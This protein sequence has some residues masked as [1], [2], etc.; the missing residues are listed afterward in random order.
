[1]NKITL[2]FALLLS[3]R[4]FGQDKPLDPTPTEAAL[5]VL[6]TDLKDKPREGELITFTSLK[7]KKEYSGVTKKDGKFY[8]LIPKGETYKVGY[9]AFSDTM[10]Y[11]N[12]PIPVAK[13]T[14]L[15]FEFQLK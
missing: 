14:L 10:Q 8:I 13:D 5:T 12:L 15:S 2:I 1:M 3:I 7:T 11:A 4:F 9:K 6:V